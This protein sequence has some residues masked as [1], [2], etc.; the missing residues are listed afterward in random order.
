MVVFKALAE[1]RELFDSLIG[2]AAP[3]LLTKQEL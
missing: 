2:H 1:F 3:S